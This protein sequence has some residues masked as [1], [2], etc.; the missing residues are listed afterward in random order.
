M[1]VP[2]GAPPAPATKLK[3]VTSILPIYCL[4]L[5]VAG[6][7][8]VVENLMA[9]GAD[10]HDFQFTPRERRALDRAG[11]VL[12]NGLGMEPWLQ[13]AL[14]RTSARPRVVEVSA[15]LGDKQAGKAPN[16]HVWLDPLLA[17]GM[18]T[19]IL[20]ALRDVDPG[21]AG[22]YGRQATGTV[23]R[24]ER[25]H[26]ELRS[27]LQPFRGAALITYHDAFAYF[28]RRYGLSIAGVIE[29]VPDLEPTPGHLRQLREAVRQQR[30]KAIFT[31]PHHS[32]RLARQLGDDLNIPVAT[33]DTLENGPLEPDAYEA[34][35]RR[36]LRVLEQS[37]R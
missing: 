37:L 4:T 10:A 29:T 31:E 24:L 30:V 33:L 21:N 19:N 1:E 6:D 22:Y 36:N 8:A 9:T 32:G 15:G 7:R 23:V 11:V 12:L 17:C 13:T 34:G 16:P 18:V 28:A 27:R 26:E 35:M 3:V 5:S 20:K 2:A 25:L 14:A